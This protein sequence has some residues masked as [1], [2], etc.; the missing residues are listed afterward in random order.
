METQGHQCI[1]ILGMH[2]SG[3]SCL[4]GIMQAAGVELGEVRRSST[5]NP[6]GN[7]ELPA[8]WRLND[9]ILAES[10]GSWKEPRRSLRWRLEHEH[11]R[12]RILSGLGRHSIWGIKDPRLLFTLDFWT[13]G[14]SSYRVVAIFRHPVRVAK[15]LFAREA[16]PQHQALALWSSYNQRLI[17]L[18][19]RRPFPVVCFDAAAETLRRSC[20]SLLVRLGLGDRVDAGVAFFEEHLRRHRDSH[21]AAETEEAMALY[22]RLLQLPALPVA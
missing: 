16:L 19:Q 9:A 3:T 22:R 4:A 14:L 20:A 13:A 5:H 10:G 18:Y 12:D 17:D 2:R 1:F 11:E 6:K 21:G 7:R 15:S 8:V